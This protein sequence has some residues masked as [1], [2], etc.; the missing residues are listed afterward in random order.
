VPFPFLASTVTPASS[1]AKERNSQSFR[2]GFQ[3]RLER[4][5][6]DELI[7]LERQRA[8]LA[9]GDLLLGLGNRRVRKM[10]ERRLDERKD[11]EHIHGAVRGKAGGANL[12]GDAHAPIDLHAAGIAALHLRQE[13]RR[14]LLLDEHGAHAAQAEI[15]GES[16]AGRPATHDEDLRVERPT[17]R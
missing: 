12:I 13:G 2:D 9:R 8:V 4:V 17:H 15:H 7:G 3:E 10:Q 6:R 1:C 5:L 11:D 16:E 14:L